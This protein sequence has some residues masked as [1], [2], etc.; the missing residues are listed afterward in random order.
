[1]VCPA[2][3][4]AIAMEKD[5]LTQFT[6]A[7]DGDIQDENLYKIFLVRYKTEKDMSGEH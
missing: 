3:V 5:L 6:D 1:M 4:L 7:V 2:F